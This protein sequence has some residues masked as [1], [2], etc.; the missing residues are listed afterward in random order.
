MP[1]L[2]KR[3][4]ALEQ[5][6]PSEDK[7]STVFIVPMLHRE[8]SP[9]RD[10]ARAKDGERTWKR[11]PGETMQEFKERIDADGEPGKV[12]VVVLDYSHPA[13]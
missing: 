2:E 7:V 6:T 5:A 13:D 4:E 3:I 10:C 12:Q 1:T 11:R 8:D 9:E